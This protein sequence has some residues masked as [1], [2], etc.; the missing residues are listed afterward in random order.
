MP[1]GCTPLNRW[2]PM[3]ASSSSESPRTKARMGT[4]VWERALRF[5][6]LWSRKLCPPQA[7]RSL[8]PTPTP[9]QAAVYTTG[10][11][12]CN[13]SFGTASPLDRRDLQD[14]RHGLFPAGISQ[15]TASMPSTL[16]RTKACQAC[17][18]PWTN[19]GHHLHRSGWLGRG[20]E[21]LSFC[22]L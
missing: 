21:R 20:D 19:F 5:Q 22:L 14:L 1:S 16:A 9:T 6:S 17:S 4:L 15:S 2:H 3:T 8:T 18:V 13:H 10:D 12:K 7:H 11:R